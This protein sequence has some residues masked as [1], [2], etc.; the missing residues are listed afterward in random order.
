MW[1]VTRAFL[2]TGSG[3]CAPSIRRMNKS[4]PTLH[5]AGARSRGFTL[6]EMMITVAIVA[7]LAGVAMPSYFDY[8]RR[9]QLPEAQ[10]A[11][12][13]FR[14]KMEQFYQDNRAYGTAN[15]ADSATLPSWAISTP[16]LTYTSAQYFT[17]S[18]ALRNAGQGYTITATGSAGRAIG[19]VYTIND[20]NQQRTTLFKSAAVSAANSCWLI[21]GT[22]CSR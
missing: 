5:C 11:L 2:H 15:C 13:D 3:G 12:S 1:L 7:I 14:V 4:V 6:I 17:Y 8:V 21:K 9:G 20:A 19:H 22:E 16:T 18:C 10:A